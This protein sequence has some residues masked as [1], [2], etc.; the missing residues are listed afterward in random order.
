MNCRIC[1]K[2][3]REAS[4]ALHVSEAT[5]DPARMGRDEDLLS[6]RLLARMKEAM[7]GFGNICLGCFV[8]TSQLELFLI[9]AT[10]D[11]DE[12]GHAPIGDWPSGWLRE[13][14]KDPTRYR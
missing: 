9:R 3:L 8:A 5:G 2:E 1:E 6:P 10:M 11:G 4:Q 7:P 13:I 12:L 14:L